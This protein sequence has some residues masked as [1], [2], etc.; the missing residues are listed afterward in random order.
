MGI[1]RIVARWGT[2][3]FA[4]RLAIS[5]PYVGALVA[6]ATIGFAIR[7]KGPLGGTVDT[8]LNAIPYVGAVKN[9]VEL[10][11]GD[12]VPDRPSRQASPPG[13]SNDVLGALEIRPTDHGSRSAMDRSG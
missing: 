7:R 12:F 13:V 4:R 8:G 6:I 5:V 2:S 11:V 1:T 3:T 10:F 9:V